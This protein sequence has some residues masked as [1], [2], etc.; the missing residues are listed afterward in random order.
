MNAFET[1]LFDFIEQYH[2]EMMVDKAAL[3]Q[4]IE[5]RADAAS[6]EY[7]KATKDG[8]V[9]HEAMELS[10]QTLYRELDFAPIELLTEI[11]ESKNLP[12]EET[13][14]IEIYFKTKSIFDK[15]PTTIKDFEVSSER[16]LLKSEIEKYII[17]NGLFQKTT[18][19]R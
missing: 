3:K 11:A 2:P 1:R 18:S 15:Y 4:F 19:A 7:E 9:H 6:T 10:N 17:E 8:H 14:L 5:E 12:S 13:E 16:E